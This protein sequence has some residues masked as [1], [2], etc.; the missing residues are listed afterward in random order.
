MSGGVDKT[1]RGLAW[2]ATHLAALPSLLLAV[3]VAVAP[4]PATA[5]CKTDQ[6]CQSCADRLRDRHGCCPGCWYVS[7]AERD[8][9]RAK[10]RA[11]EEAE[12]ARAAEERARAESERA[13]RQRAVAEERR[14][15]AREADRREEA[16]RKEAES[17]RRAREEAESR[18]KAATEAAKREELARRRAEERAKQV[19]AEREQER[20][21]LAAKAEE[22]AAA[23]ATAARE[24]R[25]LAKCQRDEE[26]ADCVA[27]QKD[28]HDRGFLRDDELCKALGWADPDDMWSGLVPRGV[29]IGGFHAELGTG[30]PLPTAETVQP[31]LVATLLQLRGLQLAEPFLLGHVGLGYWGNLA[32]SVI[33]SQPWILGAGAGF[34][35]GPSLFLGSHVVLCVGPGLVANGTSEGDPYFASTLGVMPRA[36]VLYRSVSRTYL[37]VSVQP[38]WDLAGRTKAASFADEWRFDVA[39]GTRDFELGLWFDDIPHAYATFGLSFGFGDHEAFVGRNR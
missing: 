13:E 20:L 30:F 32:F 8:A 23:E 11:T 29:G 6:S 12:R 14:R 15:A 25:L 3:V 27:L 1:S 21:K 2:R 34:G 22:R 33:G 35:V 19:E 17:E 28:C 37:Y 26:D 16:A 24:A 5:A 7:D 9:Q 31:K 10:Q 18:S 39:A 36:L 4:A 38:T